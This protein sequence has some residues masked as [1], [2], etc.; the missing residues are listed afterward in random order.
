MGGNGTVISKICVAVPP[1]PSE[2]VITTLLVPPTVG[3][4]ESVA[5]LLLLSVKVN[6]LGMVVPVKVNASPSASVAV[7]L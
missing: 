7:I 6:Q 5:V 3:V 2:R 4:P 1:L